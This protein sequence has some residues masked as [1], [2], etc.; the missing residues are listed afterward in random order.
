M[1][2]TCA[3]LAG[4]WAHTVYSVAMKF[5]SSP[6][7]TIGYFSLGSNDVSFVFGNVNAKQ[8]NSELALTYVHCISRCFKTGGPN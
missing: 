7:T 2:Y 6:C 1:N 5:R 3:L 4:L 8:T